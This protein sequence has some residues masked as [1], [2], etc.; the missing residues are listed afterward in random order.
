MPMTNDGLGLASLFRRTCQNAP[1]NWF[2]GTVIGDQFG[3]V[4]RAIRDRKL[5]TGSLPDTTTLLQRNAKYRIAGLDIACPQQV[6]SQFRVSNSSVCWGGCS[7][8]V[9][10]NLPG[11]FGKHRVANPATGVVSATRPLNKVLCYPNPPVSG[12]AGAIHAIPGASQ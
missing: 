8:G 10:I 7:K 3:L 1:G 9:G 6:Q 11:G 12:L 4:R 5:K 2:S